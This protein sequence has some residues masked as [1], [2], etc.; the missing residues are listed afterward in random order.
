MTGKLIQIKVIKT[1]DTTKEPWVMTIQDNLEIRS[2][3]TRGK[4][5]LFDYRDNIYEAFEVTQENFLRLVPHL[6]KHL[7]N[8]SN[9]TRNH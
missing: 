7:I 8:N 9:G 3:L 5:L 2:Y 1:D 4:K 6:D